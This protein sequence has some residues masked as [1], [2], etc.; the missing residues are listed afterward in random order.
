MRTHVVVGAL[1]ALGFL[2]GCAHQPEV[3]PTAAAKP[4]PVAQP[5]PVAAPAPG[6]AV[7]TATEA[8][9]PPL[10][11]IHFD[12]DKSVIH[13]EDFGTLNAIGSF[14][15]ANLDRV[16]TIA[17]HCDER[18]TVEY[19][20]ALGDR[21]AQSAKDFL[22]RLG[23]AAERIKTISYGEERPVDPGHDETAWVKNRR[24]EFQLGLKERAQ[25]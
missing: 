23:V 7:K 17:G 12:F 21:R 14:L 22:V 4:A 10:D 6:P 20:I 2:F 15:V 13:A 11:A 25:K 5:A 8:A 24:D 3:K 1:G 16:I 18:G 9:L 19:N